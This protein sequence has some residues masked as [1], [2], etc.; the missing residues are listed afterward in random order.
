MEPTGELLQHERD[1]PW[2]GPNKND[3]RL[4]AFGY[5]LVGGGAHQS[6]TLMLAEIGELLRAGVTEATDFRSK[7]LDENILG[8]A[9]SN[10]RESAFRNLSSLYGLSTVPVL[11]KAFLSFSKNDRVDHQL[12]ALLIALSRDP[13]LRDSALPVVDTTVSMSAQWPRFAA[14]FNALHPGRFSEKMVRSLSQ[15]CASTW[16]QTGHLEGNKKQRKKVHPSAPAAALAALIATVCGFSGPAILSS[17]WFRILDLDPD[18]A[19][20]ALRS[21]EAHGYARVRAA[22]DVIEISVRQQLAQTLGIPEL[23]HV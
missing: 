7:V 23:E 1:L 11:T 10:G 12:L 20:D 5:R 16:T 9:T 18:T 13:L 14:R 17:G 3:D 4:I 15:N 19:L 6:K 21:A 8:K 2:Y 22:G